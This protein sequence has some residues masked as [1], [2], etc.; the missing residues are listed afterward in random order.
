[1]PTESYGNFGLA[2]RDSLVTLTI[3]ATATAVTL[4]EISDNGVAPLVYWR[5][6]YLSLGGN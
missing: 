5:G 6:S 4:V 1:M 3:M 2:R